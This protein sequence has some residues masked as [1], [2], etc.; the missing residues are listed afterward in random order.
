MRNEALFQFV[1]PLAFLGIWALTRLCRRGR[2]RSPN[3][4][5]RAPVLIEGDS[6][7]GR[8]RC[9]IRG[10]MFATLAVAILLSLPLWIGISLTFVAIWALTWLFTRD[11]QPLPPRPTRAPSRC[12]V[13]VLWGSPREPVHEGNLKPTSTPFRDLSAHPVDADIRARNDGPRC[14][15]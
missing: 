12:P 6:P 7:P 5:T 11:D 2:R 8:F 4:L 13:D 14:N 15:G 1:V 10:L 9:T 3:R